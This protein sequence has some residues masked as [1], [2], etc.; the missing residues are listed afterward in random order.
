MNDITDQTTGELASR[1][2]VSEQAVRTL[3][4]AMKA[5]GGSM[6]QFDHPELGGMGQWSRGGMTMVG[7]MFNHA[8]KA[9]VNG[10]SGE[11]SR[12]LQQ[13]GSERRVPRQMPDLGQDAPI[14]LSPSVKGSSLDVWWGGDFGSLSANGSQNNMRYAYFANA[15]RLAI[16]TEDGITVYDTGDHEIHGVSQQQSGNTSLSFASQH[17]VVPIAT[18]RVVEKRP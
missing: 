18:L 14:G 7:D 3:L 13:G 15:R 11:I 8:L 1:Y 4:E 16:K 9:K 5:G 17:G 10:L 12:L 2:G 6:A